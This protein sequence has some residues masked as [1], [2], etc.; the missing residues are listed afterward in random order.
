MGFKL[1]NKGMPSVIDKNLYIHVSMYKFIIYIFRYFFFKK[2]RGLKFPNQMQNRCTCLC[3]ID[4]FKYFK[5][6]IQI[7]A[8]I[9]RKKHKL[10]RC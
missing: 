9:K 3:L 2:R 5:I 7:K 1:F 10:H 8:D 6:Y 4:L